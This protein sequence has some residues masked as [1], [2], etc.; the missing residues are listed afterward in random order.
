MRRPEEFPAAITL[1]FKMMVAGYRTFSA[2]CSYAFGSATQDNVLKNMAPSR[3]R[4][5][6]IVMVTAH[7]LFAFSIWLNPVFYLFEETLGIEIATGAQQTRTQVAGRVVSRTLFVGFVFL[8]AD[9]VPFFGDIMNIIGGGIGM[10]CILLLPLGSYL[11]LNREK[12]D[13]KVVVMIGVLMV[14]GV[15]IGVASTVQAV[16]QMAGKAHAEHSVA[17]KG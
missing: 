5:L 8:V 1:S 9:A 14:F 10:G 11:K 12:L 7:V 13:N 2:L 4:D 17:S 16:N 3:L 15:F 6:A